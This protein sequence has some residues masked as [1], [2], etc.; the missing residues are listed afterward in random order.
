MASTHFSVP[1]CYPAQ[2]ETKQF[3]NQTKARN[4]QTGEDSFSFI[5]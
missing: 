4:G 1:V 2:K 3:F 5:S